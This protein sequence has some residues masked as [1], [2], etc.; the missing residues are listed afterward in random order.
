MEGHARTE[1]K[2]NHRFLGSKICTICRTN[3]RPQPKPFIK[4]E[5]S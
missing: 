3:S 2:A 1:K 5:F 4:S